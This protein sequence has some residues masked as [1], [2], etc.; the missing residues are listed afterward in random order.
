MADD[1][2]SQAGLVQAKVGELT[3]AASVRVFPQLPWAE[4]FDGMA[5]NSVPPTWVNATLKYIVRELNGNKVLVKTTEG[6]S[7]LSRAR[8]TLA[9][10][11]YQLHGRS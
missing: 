11:I 3:G 9:P 2:I 7:L 8:A 10:R 6:S 4:N 5:A 1:S